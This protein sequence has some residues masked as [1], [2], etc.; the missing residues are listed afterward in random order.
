M[1]NTTPATTIAAASQNDVRTPATEFWRNS[2]SRSWPSAPASS[3]CCWS[4]WRSSPLDRAVRRREL[5][6]LRRAQ[7]RPLADPLA[8]RGLAGP[9]HLQPHRDGRPHL[10]GRR[11][12]V[13][14]HGRHRRH[15]H[16]PDG[17]LLRRLVGTH[18]HARLG[19]AAGLPRHAAG[20]R[21]GRHPG[22][23][24]GQRDRGRGRVQRAGLRPPGARQHAV[25]QADDLRR[26]GQERGRVRLDHHHAPHPARH[27][28]ADRGVRH[29]AYRHL[30]HHRGQ[31][32]VP[33]H[34][35]LASHAR[36]GRDAERGPRRHGDRAARGH[37]P[38]AGDLPDR[39][40][41]QPAGRRLR[42]ALDPKIDR[43]PRR[44]PR[45][46]SGARIRRGTAAFR[47]LE[48]Y[49]AELDTQASDIPRIG[50][51]PAGPWIPSATSATSPWAMSRWPM[52]HRRPA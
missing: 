7:R 28:L 50:D 16:G 11:L 12:P 36:V 34:G 19:R 44:R 52:A 3:S 48:R 29:D 14:L 8:G 33:G 51:L 40:G 31:P 27:D 25:D 2:R 41:V 5:L 30:D 35:R 38:G 47:I 21:R 6:R 46:P 20:H 13:R 37:L 32:V 39:A 10:A 22:L 17:G 49:M 45:A 15:L 23:Q 42:D 24:H 18:H 26:S 1:S 4:W 9:R 43:N